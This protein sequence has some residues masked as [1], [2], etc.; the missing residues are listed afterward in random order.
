[1]EFSR[2]IDRFIELHGDVDGAVL[3]AAA[4]ELGETMCTVGEPAC[5]LC[6]IERYC[7]HLHGD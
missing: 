7:S 4:I 3:Y 5:M 6:P 2:A 1:M